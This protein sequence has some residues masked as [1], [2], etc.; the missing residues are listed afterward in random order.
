MI[1]I[2]NIWDEQ[3]N[4]LGCLLLEIIPRIGETIHFYDRDDKYRTG[5]IKRV[6]HDYTHMQ[7]HEKEN[8]KTNW[9]ENTTSYIRYGIHI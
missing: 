3:E 6:S 2:G 8:K 1:V 4:D 7:R 9:G 5:T